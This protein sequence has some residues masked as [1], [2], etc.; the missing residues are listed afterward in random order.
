MTI[1]ELIARKRSQ[2]SE[3]IARRN[4]HSAE[5][6]ELRGQENPDAEKVTEIREAK[7]ALDTEIDAAEAEV[8]ALE[9]E[10]ASD[11][12]FDARAAQ[13]VPGAALPTADQRSEV[14]SEPRTYRADNDRSGVS[15]LTDVMRSQIFGDAKA[16]ERINRHMDEERVERGD[17]FVNN[18]EQRAV[19]SGAF[20]GLIV[21]QYLVDLYAPTAR[22]GRPLADAMTHHDLPEEGMTVEISR[23]TTGT[24]AA[25]QSSENSSV[26]ETDIDDTLL[27]VPVRTAA[28]SQTVSR[29]AAQRGRVTLDTVLQDLFGA[30]GTS[31]DSAIINTASVGLSAI[32][33]A[34]A[35]TDESPTAAELYPKLLAS[36]A[37]MIT[38][39]LNQYK[40]DPLFVMTPTR[41]LWL[42]SAMVSTWPL[43]GQPGISVQQGGVNYAEKL[44]GGYAGLLPNGAPV[45][46]DASI[47][48]NKGT[49]T[50][51]DE[52]YS[53]PRSEAHLWEDPN[54]PFF[55][56]AEQT[57]A[58]SLGI[59]LVVYS[60]F[61][62]TFGR[63]PSAIRKVGGTGLVAPTF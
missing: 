37:A 52:I 46:M 20:S 61:A 10:L 59:D 25:V 51:E 38:A 29:Q 34:T 30:H 14:V 21:P 45:V 28:G 31:I 57:N 6:R 23:G 62:F 27:S 19:G 11:R 2:I 36:Q 63:Y 16:M 12:V 39:L 9:K 5:L 33:T 4:A 58:K 17:R 3:L 53:I 47:P 24:S 49:G 48:T 44:G 1:E 41:W 22:A 40:N 8:A 60:F 35:Y 26:S 56:R 32:A 43:I 18:Q 13:S 50:N 15:F 54:A 7:D 42:Q 55:I